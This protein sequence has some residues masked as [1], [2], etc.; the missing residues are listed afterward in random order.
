MLGVDEM[1]SRYLN[2]ELNPE[3]EIYFI[4]F[5]QQISNS[6]R[7]QKYQA[8]M[9]CDSP[10]AKPFKEYLLTGTLKSFDRPCL[11]ASSHKNVNNR[12]SSIT[13]LC[14]SYHICVPYINFMTH[15]INYLSSEH[16]SDGFF[17]TQI[18]ASNMHNN[19]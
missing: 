4:I 18:E 15:I 10:R 2:N 9:L 14:L 11:T 16:N 12:E 13:T 1:I 8:V 19:K 17:H 3:L 7:T 5:L 6:L